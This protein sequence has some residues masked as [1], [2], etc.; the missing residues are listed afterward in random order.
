MDRFIQNLRKDKNEY[1]R[2]DFEVEFPREKV[3]W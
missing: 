3:T 1:R 2:Q